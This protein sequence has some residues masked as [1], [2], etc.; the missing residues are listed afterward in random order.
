MGRDFGTSLWDDFVGR[1]ER[2]SAPMSK[3]NLNEEGLYPN[4]DSTL[5][6][7]I[8]IILAVYIAVVSL[9]LRSKKKKWQLLHPFFITIIDVSISS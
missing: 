4:T 5:H 2:N 3:T 7:V 9:L 8:A 1:L 6:S